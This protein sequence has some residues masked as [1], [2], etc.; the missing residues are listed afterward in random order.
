MRLRLRHESCFLCIFMTCSS[1]R[2]AC[3][4][5]ALQ[6]VFAVATLHLA[7][8]CAT[9]PNPAE[10]PANSGTSGWGSKTTPPSF[11]VTVS[12]AVV[13]RGQTAT[14]TVKSSLSSSTAIKVYYSLGGTAIR[15]TDYTVNVASPVT[16]PAG[17]TS[18][19]VRLSALTQKNRTATMTLKSGTGYGLG[20]P[21]STSV[22]L[23]P[24]PTPTPTPSPTPTLRRRL[25]QHQLRRRHQLQHQ[26]R[27]PR[28]HQRQHQRLVQRQLPRRRRHKTSGLRCALMGYPAQ[29]RRPTHSMAVR[30]TNLIPSCSTT[31]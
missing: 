11:S 1:I 22:T 25:A 19:T 4:N 31:S 8:S 6:C 18:T 3:F 24:T 7:A 12:P 29:A 2:L 9:A 20:T 10:G 21:V 30:W 16:I 14:Y 26:L 17:A 5:R 28:Q 13:S 23:Q 15:G 27:R